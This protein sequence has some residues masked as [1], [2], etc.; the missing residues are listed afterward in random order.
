MRI[1]F[2]ALTIALWGWT[3]CKGSEAPPPAP[4]ETATAA[5]ETTAPPAE[6]AAP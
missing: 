1:V 5:P 6:D 3:G 4:P 2:V